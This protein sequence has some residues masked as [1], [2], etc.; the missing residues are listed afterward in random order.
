MD[1]MQY[2]PATESEAPAKRRGR[3]PV[4]AGAV[5]AALLALYI[6]LCVW[7]AVNGRI[8]PNVQVGGLQVGGMTETQAE[9]LITAET[10]ARF[11]SKSV[12]L[13][14][15]GRSARF[16]GSCVTA[17]ASAAA[18]SASAVGRSG[19]PLLYGFS[20][21]RAWTRPT[22]LS[23]PLQLD[24]ADPQGVD[25]LD[26]LFRELEWAVEPSRWDLTEEGVQVV[27]GRS[28]SRYDR[29]AVAQQ[30]LQAIV[31][32]ADGG[33]ADPVRAEPVRTPPDPLDWQAIAG[34]LFLSPADASID[35]ETREILPSVTGVSLDVERA[36]R[37]YDQADEGAGFTIPLTL[38]Q[39]AV[40]TELLFRDVLGEVQT[41]ISGVA[42][43]VANVALAAE[44][45]HDIL[46]LPGDVFSYW[47]TVGPCSAAQGFLPAPSY[48][49]GATV[50]SV[51]GGICQVSSSI[52]Y[53]ALKADLEIVERQN[54]SYAVGYVPDGA[55]ATVYS[56]HPDFRFKNSTDYPIRIVAYAKGRSLTVRLE[57][58]K[59][60]DTYVQMQFVELSRTQPETIYKADESV[61]VGTTRVSVT[62]YTGRKVEAYRCVYSGDGT[63]LSKTLESVNNYKKRDKVVLC[64]PADLY[65]YD[66]TIPAPSPSPSQQPEV[67]LEPSPSESVPPAQPTSSPEESAALPAVPSEDSGQAEASAAPSQGPDEASPAPA[68]SAES[69]EAEQT[70]QETEP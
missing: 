66:P 18:L 1:E 15:A 58:T 6:G 45:C 50:D 13:I 4:L 21:L 42:N 49:N 19:S 55:D 8:L 24:T 62:A 64:N 32:A 43:R 63:L 23:L 52:Y 12:E 20:Y 44:L 10:Q 68:P 65:L 27:K 29:E 57:G 11:A 40:T 53:A 41:T 35:P 26:L 67:D 9:Q 47:D 39:P 14:C 22:Q 16:S 59:T 51:G 56:G 34:Q 2:Y 37:L 31:T 48:V 54:H 7:V 25:R 38:T 60:D 3:L 36:R 69:G 17:D 46:L 70:T 5:L 61:P 30:L 28:G 33:Q